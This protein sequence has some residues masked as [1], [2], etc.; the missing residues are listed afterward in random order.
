MFDTFSLGARINKGLTVRGAQMHE[1]RHIPLLLERME[2]GSWSPSTWPPHVLPL[3]EG[4]EGY[5]IFIDK[6]DDCVRN[7]F[8]PHG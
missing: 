2:R 7:V 5:R 4:P 8:L 3:S 1:Q 6:K